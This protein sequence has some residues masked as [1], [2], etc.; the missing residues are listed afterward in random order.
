MDMSEGAYVIAKKV[1]SGTI[2]RT[3]GK[4]EINKVTGMSEGSAQA[5]ITIFIAMMNGEKYKRAFNNETNRFLL[6]NIRKDFG[7]TNY[8]NA[9]IAVQKHIDYY[10]TL[11]KGNLSGLQ[12]IIDEMSI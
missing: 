5:F 12:S 3:M 7:E 4:V 10:S 11:G 2:T 1:Y 9:L 6:E 8:K